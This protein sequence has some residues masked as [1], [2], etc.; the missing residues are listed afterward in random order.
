MVFGGVKTERLTLNDDTLCSGGPRDWNNPGAKDHLPIVRKLVLVDKNYQ[1]ADDE[2]R[3]M[4]GPWNQNYEPVGDLLIEME[5]G[6]EVASYKRSLDLD[7]AVAKVEYTAGGVRY[8]REVF[9]SFPDD[10]IVVRITASQ[11]SKLNATLRMKSL[12]H[13]ST[14]A[15]GTSLLLTG[16]APKQSLPQYVSTEPAVIYSDVEGE[17]MHFAS[18]VHVKASGGKVEAQPDGSLHVTGASSLVMTVG[19]ATGFKGFAS[20]PDMPLD[21]VIAKAKGGAERAGHVPYETLL[22][23]HVE[24]HR[25]LFRRVSLE[26][27]STP[28]AALAT[29]KRVEAF[30]KT[31]DPS[32]LV[33]V[34][35]LGRYLLISS[36]RPGSQ[37]ANL[38]GLWST[39]VRPPWSC[40]W[41]TNINVEMNYWAAETCNLSECHLP[42]IDMVRDLSVNGAKTAK[43]NYG[44]PGWCAHHNVDLWRQS[45]PAGNGEAWAM[46]T[47]ANWPMAGVWLCAHLWEHYRFTGDKQY[48]R[49]VAYPVMRG[50]AEFCAGWL[51]D[52]GQGG[53]TTCPSVSPENVFIAPNGQ[54]A[55]VS[56]GTTMDMA[57]IR[58]IFANCTE[59]SELLGVDAEFRDRMGTLTQRLPPYKIGRFGQL[60]EWSIDFEEK[61]PGMRHLSHLY[62]VYPGRQITPLGTPE[63]AVAARKSLERRLEFAFKEAGAFT[64]WGRSWVIALWARF[65]D[66]EMAWDSLKTLVNHSLNGNLFDDVNDTHSEPNVTVSKGVPGFIFQIDANLGTP[67]GIAELLLQSHTEEI[68]FLPALPEAW[69]Q[70][71]V[72]GLRARGGAE[73]SIEWDG[74]A[75]SKA[76]VQT[77]QDSAYRFRAPKGQRLLAVKKRSGATWSPHAMPSG[78]GKTFEIAGRKGE[79]YRFSFGRD[80]A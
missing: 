41:T 37:P 31:A 77:M 52:D 49:E 27:P 44:A 58:E 8:Q 40:N 10:A 73:I 46:P 67:G 42:L 2:C 60:Q 76:T 56:A 18:A 61:Y 51:I 45:A 68:A 38:Q 4:E 26:L 30:A 11:P 59:A 50:S 20:A 7:T 32:L 80:L 3:K 75:S 29:D 24:D 34:F 69:P 64:G 17:G 14:S 19:C 62:P 15:Q 47:W 55:N 5:H 53:L 16:K 79:T 72:R 70:G 63:L 12:L 66:G 36:S 1:A 6:E 28:D 65:Q 54:V 33:L 25:K 43:I 22:E 78:D 35:N 9:A 74:P 39:D 23:R 13:S 48:L 71:K 57:L 21:R